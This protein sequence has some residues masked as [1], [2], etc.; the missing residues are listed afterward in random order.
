MLFMLRLAH[1][2]TDL[3]V[4]FKVHKVL[5]LIWRELNNYEKERMNLILMKDIA[6]MM[7]NKQR[8]NEAYELLGICYMEMKEYE[9]ALKCFKK[10][11]EYAWSNNDIDFEIRAYEKIFIQYFYLGDLEKSKFYHERAIRGQIIG[12]DLRRVFKRGNYKT[13]RKNSEKA[14]YDYEEEVT[15]KMK[16]ATLEKFKQ[17]LEE[18]QDE[19][20]IEELIKETSERDTE[21]GD[22]MAKEI[23]DEG[24][25]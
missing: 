16:Y 8:K 4:L 2:R 1:L 7:K 14:D 9:K 3:E 10:Q 11:L 17:V 20:L 18:I 19:L 25:Q 5:S 23:N 15:L 22:I 21:E 6:G 24:L 12:D 13:R